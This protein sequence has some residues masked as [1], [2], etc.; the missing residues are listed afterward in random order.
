M[1]SNNKSVYAPA[2]SSYPYTIGISFSEGTPSTEN[3][4]SP[5]TIEGTLYG[6][7]I[8]FSGSSNNTLAIYWIDNNKNTSPK[9]VA[10]KTIQSTSRGTTYKVSA[11]IDV[12]HKDDGTLSGY[13]RVVWTKVSTNSYVP[14]TTTIDTANTTLTTIARTTKLGNHTGTIGETMNFSWSKASSSFTH[15]LT[16]SFGGKTGTIGTNLVDGAS[17]I[18]PVELYEVLSKSSGTG[19]ISLTTYNGS[20]QIGST[21]TATLTLNAKESDTAPIILSKS[22]IDTN[23]TTK[24]LTGDETIL[25]IHQSITRLDIEFTTRQYAKATKLVIN[26][27]EYT[28]PTG[29]VQSDGTTT[30][31]NIS[32]DLGTSKTYDFVIRVTDS[33][34]M[35]IEDYMLASFITYI[36]LGCSSTFKRV[37]PTTGVVGLKFNGRFLNNF[38]ST[39][40]ELKINYKYKKK[41]EDTYSDLITLDVNTDYKISNNLFYSGT[42][43][44]AEQITLTPSFDY[45]SVYEGVLYVEDKLT[46]LTINFTIVKGVPIF[47]WNGEKVVVNGGLYVADND[48]ENVSL[49]PKTAQEYLDSGEDVYS[50][51]YVNQELQSV[52]KKINENTSRSAIMVSISSSKTISSVS[53]WAWYS[54]AFDRVA[55]NIGDKFSL[56]SD[57]TVNYSGTRP[58]KV[59][60]HI[61]RSSDSTCGSLYPFVQSISDFQGQAT[62]SNPIFDFVYIFENTNN[63]KAWITPSS[64]GKAIFLGHATH[65]YTYMLV[66]EL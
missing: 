30:K 55:K 62:A 38:G 49:V 15:E 8:N 14:P 53:A 50:C 23:E 13:A 40:N 28:I 65:N 41:S 21:Q 19:T 2:S 58:I 7:Y 54:L 18:P 63:L 5:I 31:Y 64:S 26:D 29:E 24:A 52:D 3:N 61:N 6:K 11:T 45:K 4:T 16:Y 1:G 27:I 43:D 25:L 66:E 60:L 9:L 17:W 48:G 22:A 44:A 33:R 56:A 20:N 59:T 57:G 10:T 35:F 39:A 32:L 42:G 34:E 47:W 36:P 46:T 51:N 12:P 37:S